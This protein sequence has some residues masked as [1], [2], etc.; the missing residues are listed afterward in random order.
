MYDQS[1]IAVL[2]SAVRTA[3]S[4][5]LV[6]EVADHFA[7]YFDELGITITVKPETS[8]EQVRELKQRITP[9]LSQ[10]NRSN[11]LSCFGV[12]ASRSPSCSRMDYSRWVD[13]CKISISLIAASRPETELCARSFRSLNWTGRQLCESSSSLWRFQRHYPSVFGALVLPS[14]YGHLIRFLPPFCS[15]QAA[16]PW[17]RCC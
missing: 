7:G 9:L 13:C 2:T 15:Q 5:P 8:D 14:K 6:L 1:Q 12:K 16:R 10:R 17:F 3:L 11:G 4:D